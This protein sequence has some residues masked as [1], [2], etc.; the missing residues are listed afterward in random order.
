ML[1]ETQFQYNPE[2]LEVHPFAIDIESPY[3]Q[4]CPRNK[5]PL[6]HHANAQWLYNS[7]LV[8]LLVRSHLQKSVWVFLQLRKILTIAAENSA[9]PSVTEGANLPSDVWRLGTEPVELLILFQY[10]C[11][12][13]TNAA[14]EASLPARG[15]HTILENAPRS[16][17]PRNLVPITLLRRTGREPSVLPIDQPHAQ[18]AQ[19]Q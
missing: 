9:V 15:G 11:S 8:E 17:I 18:P 16:K 1:S 6:L 12:T 7:M 2:N 5:A 3:G 10:E 13:Q 19:V 4:H 14:V